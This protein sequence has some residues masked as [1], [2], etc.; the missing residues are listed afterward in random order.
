VYNVGASWIAHEADDWS[1]RS[2]FFDNPYRPNW[3]AEERSWLSFSSPMRR[4]PQ[5]MFCAFSYIDVNP[6]SNIRLGFE[7][8]NWN[9]N[10]VECRMYTWM[11]ESK[12]NQLKG[13][14][15]AIL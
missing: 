7:T 11:D 2:G 15:V 5:H 6:H 4:R 1:I 9:E 12:F 13:Y 10:S 14:Y 3:A 8:P